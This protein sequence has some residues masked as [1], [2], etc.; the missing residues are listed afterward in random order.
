MATSKIS[1][2][3]LAANRSNANMST[4]PRSAAGKARSRRNAVK[5][6][7][8]GAGVAL[9]TEDAAQVE[10]RFAAVVPESKLVLIGRGLDAMA[11]TKNLRAFVGLF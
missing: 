9:P 3:R 7:L 8:T 5:H 2:A 4:D 11:F 10:A 1:P 6:G